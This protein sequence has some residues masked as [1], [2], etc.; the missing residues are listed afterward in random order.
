MKKIFLPLIVLALLLTACAPSAAM[1]APEAPSP[2]MENGVQPLSIQMDKVGGQSAI[3]NSAAPAVERMVIQNANLTLTVSDPQTSLNDI[4]RLAKDLG[5]YVVSTNLY[6]TSLANGGKAPRAEIV[7][8]V[9]QE[10]LDEALTQIKQGAVEVSAENR[11]GQDV[12]SEYTDLASRLRNLENAEK[13][14]TEIMNKATTA[15]ETLNVFNQ[16]TS[17]REQ[18][19]VIKGQMQYYE[20]SAALSAINISLIA[21]A[22]VQPLEVGGWR[23]QGTARDALQ[24]LIN[25]LKGFGDFLIFLVIFILPAGALILGLLALLWRGLRWLWRKLFPKKAAPAKPAVQ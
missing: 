14:L 24:M 9:P 8:R 25:F 20:Q 12:T 13:Q 10:K 17:I 18:I 1:P 7:V 3:A 11:S 6:E 21:E 2:A 22:S 19:E 15:D 16:L 23:P 4:S 5:G